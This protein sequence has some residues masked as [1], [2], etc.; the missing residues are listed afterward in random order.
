MPRASTGSARPS[1]SIAGSDGPRVLLLGGCQ[2]RRAEAEVSQQP[3]GEPVHPGMHYQP[4]S[5]LPGLLHDRRAAKPP[6]TEL[7]PDHQ[8]T[9]AAGAPTSGHFMVLRTG[10]GPGLRSGLGSDGVVKLPIARRMTPQSDIRACARVT[11]SQGNRRESAA[12]SCSHGVIVHDPTDPIGTIFFNY[13]LALKAP[14]RKA[15]LLVYGDVVSVKITLFLCVEQRLNLLVE[16]VLL[17][18]AMTRRRLGSM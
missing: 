17:L 15:E 11:F 3:V 6:H 18:L 1:V 16:C 14:V 13:L 2:A 10:L 5:A 4:L 9:G 7:K 8:A 12:A